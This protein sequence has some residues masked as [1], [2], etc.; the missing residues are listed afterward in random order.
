MWPNSYAK[1]R[2]KYDY[3]GQEPAN[4]PPAG[5]IWTAAKQAG[6]SMRNYGYYV[7]NR[8]K[9]EADGTQITDVRDPILAP[10]TD[11]NYRGFDLDYP[12]IERAKEFIEI[13]RASCSGRVDRAG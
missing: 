8:D 5:Y 12:D 4:Q 6:V 3:E 2:N 13:G 7:S 1:R 10:V 9:P 11:P